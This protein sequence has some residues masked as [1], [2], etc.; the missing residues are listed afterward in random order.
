MA[1]LAKCGFEEAQGYDGMALSAKVDGKKHDVRLCVVCDD[2]SLE[3]ALAYARRNVNVLLLEYHGTGE[4][5]LYKQ[6][7]RDRLSGVRLNVVVE[8]GM[9][10]DEEDV[11]SLIAETPQGVR[12]VI[13]LPDEY[14]DMRSITRLS[15][16]YPSVRFYGNGLF[17]LRGSRV[18]RFDENDL[19]GCGVKFTQS[20]E[21]CEPI[22]SMSLAELEITATESHEKQEKAA[23][24]S[25]PKQKVKKFSDFIFA[26]GT[27]DL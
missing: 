13:S 5:P 22:K 6:L 4:F 26:G 12:L 25:A 1:V 11:R 19:N 21:G 23:T 17:P 2:L 14:M 15:S 18:G 16:G 9:D 8:Q 24:A 10:M 3:K 27:F 20:Y 7:T